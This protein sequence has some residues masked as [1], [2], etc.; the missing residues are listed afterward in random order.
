MILSLLEE[1]PTHAP[2]KELRV[3]EVD[4]IKFDA[5]IVLF[6]TVKAGPLLIASI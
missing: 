3:K 6:I 4:A 1:L 5:V 2:I